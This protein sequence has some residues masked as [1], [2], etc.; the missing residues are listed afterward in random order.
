LDLSGN[1]MSAEGATA[2]GCGLRFAC[3]RLR[4]LKLGGNK[5]GSEGVSGLVVGMLT[6]AAAAASS[7]E[8]AESGEEAGAR[9]CLQEL[10]LSGNAVTGGFAA[11][12][13]HSLCI[14]YRHN[15]CAQCSSSSRRRRYGQG[16]D[17]PAA[18][19][20]R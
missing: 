1:S 8:C 20:R 7:A 11:L 9:S 2:L 10:D 19:V 16:S 15:L 4:T 3:P 13:T 18:A 12:H 5:M 17:L 14:A 6:A